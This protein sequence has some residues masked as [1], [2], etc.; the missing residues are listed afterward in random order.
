MDSRRAPMG[1]GSSL[2]GTRAV[3]GP[4]V[5]LNRRSSSGCGSS[6]LKYMEQQGR[7]SSAQ[8][9]KY[10]TNQVLTDQRAI[11]NPHSFFLLATGISEYYICVIVLHCMKPWDF[12]GYF[13][14]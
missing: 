7:W 4:H 11:R 6:L 12:V 3:L 1:G 8:A 10:V 5:M 14:H 2:A 9:T 13:C